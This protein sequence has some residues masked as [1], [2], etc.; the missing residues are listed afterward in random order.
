MKLPIFIQFCFIVGIMG[1]LFDFLSWY[2]DNPDAS[3]TDILIFSFGLL[4]S[5]HKDKQL[6]CSNK[7]REIDDGS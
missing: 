4:W 3:S 6:Q 2:F 7:S 5:I 1:G